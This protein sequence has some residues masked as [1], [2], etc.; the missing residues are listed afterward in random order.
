MQLVAADGTVM[1]AEELSFKPL[2]KGK[3][4]TV[5]TSTGS[6][7]NAGNYKVILIAKDANGL[8]ISGFEMQ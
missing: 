8:I 6:S 7:I 4:G 5:S 3:S 2:T 1:K